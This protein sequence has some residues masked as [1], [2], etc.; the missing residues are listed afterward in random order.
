MK[1][2]KRIIEIR[3]KGIEAISNEDIPTIF[4][5]ICDFINLD[6]DAQKQIKDYNL[7]MQIKIEDLES[8]FLTILEDRIE[9]T[10]EPLESQD[11]VI[12][13]DLRTISKL[14][15]G[16]LDPLEAY[17]SE[18]LTIK[19]D[20][21]KVIQF[22]EILELTFAKLEI[23][24][25]SEKK[26]LFD[27]GSM[28]SLIDVY[29]KGASIVEPYHVP[30]FLEILTFFVNSNPEA[31]E[32]ILDE[33]L[34]IQLIISDYASYILHIKNCIME[35]AKGLV[36]NPDL[37]LEM[38]LQTSVETLIAGNAMSAYMEGKIIIEGNIAKALIFQNLIDIFLEF[39]NI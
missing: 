20:L 6:Q 21:F 26:L 12:S 4:Q 1:N 33:N 29:L 34:I 5:L 27:T 18:L 8:Y 16:Q 13:S 28:K 31:K 17:F 19:G 22:V 9:F 7:A 3:E 38:S 30:L 37:T 23:I 35:W 39:I 11:F 25:N 14:L 15:L 24:N 36:P 10:K 2:L 32:I